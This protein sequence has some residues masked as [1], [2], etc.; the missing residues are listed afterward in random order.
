MHV[1]VQV[2]VHAVALQHH[3]PLQSSTAFWIFILLS[4]L[5]RVFVTKILPLNINLRVKPAVFLVC[6][7]CTGARSCVEIRIGPLPQ[8]FLPYH[9]ISQHNIQH[10]EVH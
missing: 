4:S 9:E 2:C 5:E 3:F 7:F 1:F 8:P 6:S 10:S